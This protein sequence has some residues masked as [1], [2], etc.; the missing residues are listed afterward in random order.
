MCDSGFHCHTQK[1]PG[2]R[3]EAQR[4]LVEEVESFHVGLF[5]LE[6]LFGDVQE[7]LSL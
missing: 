6:E 5:G 7:L 2:K 1:K 3:E 4:Y